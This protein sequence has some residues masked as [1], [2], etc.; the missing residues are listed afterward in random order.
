MNFLVE[1]LSGS[2]FEIEVDYK[3][4]LLE[5]KQKIE[6]SQGIPVSKQTLIVDGVVILREDL[7][8]QQC[9]ILHDSLLQLDVSSDENP[10]DNGDDQIPQIEQ[11]P[12]PWISVEEHF[13]GQ[14]WPLTTD[15]IRK[16]YSYQTKTTQ[17]IN[18]V[19]DSQVM[20]RGNNRVLTRVKIESD[21][22][23]DQVL[24]TNQ[25]QYSSWKPPNMRR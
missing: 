12:E 15:E 14:G 6:K 9:Q 13:E 3:D 21:N 18:K 24:Q 25:A 20:V 16:I 22:N 5:V 10:N 2:S 8:V 23:N 4:T 11:S 7:N 17:G 1:I 19:Q